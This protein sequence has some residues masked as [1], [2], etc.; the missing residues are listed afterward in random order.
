MLRHATIAAVLA[1]ACLGCSHRSMTLADGGPGD[2]SVGPDGPAAGSRLVYLATAG[3]DTPRFIAVS[4]ATAAPAKRIGP[5]RGAG[6][7]EGEGTLSYRAASADGQRVLVEL[8]TQE[9]KQIL[10]A[11]ATDGAN[12]DAPVRV[13]TGSE[14]GAVALSPDG[15]EL[16][17][18]EQRALY[19]AGLAGDASLPILIAKPPA[20]A[21]IANPRWAAGAGRA[22]F[23]LDREAGNGQTAATIHS[24][25]LDGSDASA[26]LA[27]TSSTSGQ[28]RAQAVLPDGRV[29]AMLDKGVLHAIP[30]AGGPAVRLGP[31]QSYSPLIAVIEGGARLVVTLFQGASWPRRLAVL[32]SDGSLAEAPL[33]LTETVE[34]LQAI[35]SADGKTVA[36]VGRAQGS[37]AVF[38]VQASGAAPPARVSAWLQA[39]PFLR[40]FTASGSALVGCSNA[41]RTLLRFDRPGS[42]SSTPVVLATGP[43]SRSAPMGRGS[44]SRGTTARAAGPRSSCRSEAAPRSSSSPAASPTCSRPGSSPSSSGSR[45][46]R[47]S[48][49][50]CRAPP[51]G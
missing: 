8:R 22:V 4:D 10:Y 48:R 34:D 5:A 38:E 3:V 30:A 42:T 17:F 12:A 7:G 44:S 15:S 18:V 35:V 13:A 37:W 31:A 33:L 27:L 47:S 23:E 26:P 40:A 9:Q 28:D 32:A 49:S 14:L 29:I 6:Y 43:T 36:Y 1:S 16:L 39:R 50:G 21:T 20:G 24:A 45:P 41:E 2:A 11:L 46:R 51:S 19:R 25:R